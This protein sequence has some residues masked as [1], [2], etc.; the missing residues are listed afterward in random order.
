M[1]RSPQGGLSGQV[2][3]FNGRSYAEAQRYDCGAV[4]GDDT[5]FQTSFEQDEGGY[6]GDWTSWTNA[7][8]HNGGNELIKQFAE[9]GHEFPAGFS[10][11]RA[12]KLWRDPEVPGMHEVIEVKNDAAKAR[13]G[14]RSFVYYRNSPTPEVGASPTQWYNDG[15]LA[16]KA[17]D[18]QRY[19]Q[20]YIEYYIMISQAMVDRDIE[21]GLG[22]FQNFPC[23][24]A[25]C[26]YG[27]L[28]L[29]GW[30]QWQS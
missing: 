2:R 7:T 28:L 22:I 20:M 29:H 24:R 11:V 5:I 15:L 1:G 8:N 13:S 4:I 9:L 16:W 23:E 6:E 30:W 19:R 14:T 27:R 26:R 12:T 18:G 25:F 17:P 3:D 21:R 10:A